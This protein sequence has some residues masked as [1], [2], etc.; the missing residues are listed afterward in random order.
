MGSNGPHARQLRLEGK[1][2]PSGKYVVRATLMRADGS[3]QEAVQTLE[4]VS[5][6]PL[7]MD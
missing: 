7:V 2:M 5:G 6:R 4:V 1:G 3:T